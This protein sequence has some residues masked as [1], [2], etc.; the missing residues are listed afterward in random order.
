V[1]AVRENL[2]LLASEA[3]RDLLELHS[4]IERVTLANMIERYESMLQQSLSEGSWQRFF[5]SNVF[6]LTMVFARP[7]RLL[8]TQFHA[9]GSSLDGSGAQVGDF[10]FAEQG[11]ALAI[12]EIKKPTSV[13]MRNTPYRN[14]EVYGPSAELTGAVTQVLYQQSMLHSNWLLHR[15]QSE[16][17]ESRP[18][19]TRCVVIAGTTLNDEAQHRS[20]EVFRNACK[21]VEVVTF[22]EL[23]GKLR[24]LLSLLT[25][26]AAGA[27]D[28]IPF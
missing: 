18:D 19:A 20:F 15:A 22:D 9:Q 28:S 26:Q 6:I 11:Q 14:R 25:P 3:P 23:L 12:V 10:L 17:R 27:N 2:E 13:L 8:H 5:E 24:L 4:E 7:V 1:R 16:L 21:S